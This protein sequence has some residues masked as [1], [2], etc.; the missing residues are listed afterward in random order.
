MGAASKRGSQVQA[1]GGRYSRSRMLADGLADGLGG[2]QP[3]GR[4]VR[5]GARVLC[6]FCAR[7][8]V[9]LCGA[10]EV[11]PFIPRREC[12]LTMRTRRQPVATHGNGFGLLEPF[13]RPRHLPSAPFESRDGG[14]A[15][16]EAWPEFQPPRSGRSSRKST[17]L[18][19]S[20]AWRSR[21][22]PPHHHRL[23]SF[24]TALLGNAP[25]LSVCVRPTSESQACGSACLFEREGEPLVRR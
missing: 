22:L 20:R 19:S 5:F 2:A 7:D 10:R 14:S 9:S 18:I 23:R 11:T 24:A 21:A 25:P 4:A 12:T 6:T 3:I 17:R 16:T 8:S 15:Q 13:S 1:S